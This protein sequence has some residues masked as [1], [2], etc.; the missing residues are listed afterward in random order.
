MD[1]LSDVTPV[2][3]RLYTDLAS[4]EQAICAQNHGAP[5]QHSIRP[6]A[7]PLAR[8]E[9]GADLSMARIAGRQ[10]SG[11]TYL[12][13]DRQRRSGSVAVG[14]HWATVRCSHAVWTA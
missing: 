8:T 10:R 3:Q 13:L 1:E 9:S 11:N 5:S 4:I 14:G 12:W 6:V 2:R 7:T